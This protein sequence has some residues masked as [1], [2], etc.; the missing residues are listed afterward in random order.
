[1]LTADG[2]V[3]TIGTEGGQA[4][5]MIDDAHFVSARLHLG[6][7]DTLVLYTDGLT[8]ARI[9]RGP[10][11][12]DDHYALLDFARAHAPTTAAGIVAALRDLLRGLGS[13]V[14]DDAAVLALGVPG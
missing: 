12:Y 10:E 8:E 2:G 13:G 5:G 11:R 1:L 9:G 4:A 6:P 7:G 3:E 14:E